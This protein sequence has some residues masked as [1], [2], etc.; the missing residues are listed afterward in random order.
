MADLKEPSTSSNSV[1]GY[2]TDEEASLIAKENP[3]TLWIVDLAGSERSKRTNVG[4]LRQKEAS[5]I[6]KS[7]MNL[8]RCLTMMK[9]NQSNE[10]S[11]QIIPFRENKLTQL[12]MPIFTGR[13]A[14]HVSMI[15]NVNP[16]APDFDETNHV[17][18][19][20]SQAK[21]VTIAQSQNPDTAV[22]QVTNTLEYGYDGRPAVKKAKTAASKIKSLMKKFS[23]KKI[24]NSSKPTSKETTSIF[25]KKRKAVPPA[26]VPSFNTSTTSFSKAGT[27]TNTQQPQTKRMRLFKSNS[28]NSSS[29]LFGQSSASTTTGHQTD[30]NGDEIKYL[31]MALS[32]AQAEIEVLRS[33]KEGLVEQM[34]EI[35]T[36]VRMEVSEEMESQINN[37]KQHYQDIIDRM[38]RQ[39]RPSLSVTEKQDRM[40]KASEQID[41]L[42]FKVD[43]CE[44]EMDRMRENH[45][46]EVTELQNALKEKE[47]SH[48]A[49]IAKLKEDLSAH[50]GTATTKVVA[51]NDD[52]KDLIIRNQQMEIE[53]LKKSKLEIIHNYEKLLNEAN[54]DEEEEEHEDEDS[55][56][57]ETQNPIHFKRAAPRYTTRTNSKDKSAT[58]KPTGATASR[59]PLASISNH[60]K[61]A[62]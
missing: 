4:F 48:L 18:S 7:L 32:I 26:R 50:R 33:E 36:Q 47:T 37:T 39:I 1:S 16:A 20:A 40:E 34:G 25:D 61:G 6:N 24:G 15:V 49:E 19:Y 45:Q 56:E 46:N 29:S 11:G 27:K 59:N 17:L 38:K 5:L 13:S 57:T 30:Q 22:K 60:A 35:E 8:M 9:E 43:E 31:K 10:N 2:N 44:E 62:R 54:E 12:F 52:E 3:T 14:S 42:L 23:P 55:L 41:V 53:R 28:Q 58:M 21:M 51:G